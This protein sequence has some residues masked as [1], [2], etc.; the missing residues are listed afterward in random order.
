MRA[1]I[2]KNKVAP[3][4]RVSEFDIMYSEGI[5]KHGEL[6][7]I[8]V[9]EDIITK[10]GSFYSFGETRLGQG[11]ENSKRFLMENGEL[12]NEVENL[13]RNKLSPQIIIPDPAEQPDPLDAVASITD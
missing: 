4:F 8:G 5:S 6:L 1:R 7:D 11:R 3:P 9:N 2:V 13:V 10:S 12:A